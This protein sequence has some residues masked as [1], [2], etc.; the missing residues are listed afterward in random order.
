MGEENWGLGGIL[1]KKLTVSG[2]NIHIIDPFFII[3]GLLMLKY[4]S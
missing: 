3:F 4:G 1:G 2:L